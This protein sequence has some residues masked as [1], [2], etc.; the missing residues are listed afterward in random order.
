MNDDGTGRKDLT[1]GRAYDVSPAFSPDGRRIVF[2]KMTFGQ[3]SERS[4]LVVMR[5][6]GTN[7]RQITD[8]PRAFEYG[9][10][11]QSLPEITPTSGANSRLDL[12]VRPGS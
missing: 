1:A 6:N 5:A 10:D 12:R 9:A 7:K 2:S 4:E 8:T 11:W 3:R